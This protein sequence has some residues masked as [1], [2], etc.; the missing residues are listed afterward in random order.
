MEEWEK[1]VPE[2]PG[3]PVEAEGAGLPG[4]TTRKEQPF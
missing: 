3:E 4:G 1:A 2:D